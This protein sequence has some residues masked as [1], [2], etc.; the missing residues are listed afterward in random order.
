M[1]VV[2]SF[3]N[4]VADITGSTLGQD[5]FIGLAPS[6]N[7]VDDSIWWIVENGGGVTLKN[8]TGEMI[9]SYQYNIYYR[10]R[11]YMLVSDTMFSL[12]E[13]L[14]CDECS[15]L[16]GYDTIEIEAT[17]FPIDN[18]LDVGDKKIGLLQV[19]IT[20]YKEC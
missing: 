8:A 18:D 20:T 6:V 15:Q 17:S 5:M 16:E 13:T 7:A 12:E 2:S 4:F 10:D 14:N 3:A 11:D 19:T 9:K 1:T